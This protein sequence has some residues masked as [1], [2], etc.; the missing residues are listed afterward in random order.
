MCSSKFST[1][2]IT[3]HPSLR[4]FDF[5][6]SHNTPL[7]LGN[8]PSNMSTN[9]EPTTTDSSGG[10]SNTGG[11]SNPQP[12]PQAMIHGYFKERCVYYNTPWDYHDPNI[13]KDKAK[14][15]GWVYFVNNPCAYCMVST[16]YILLLR[17]W[18]LLLTPHEKKT[19]ILNEFVADNT[20]R[21]RSSYSTICRGLDEK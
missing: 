11:G 12:S 4:W 5:F 7:Q 17:W 3:H 14:N 13:D 19:R 9:P 10:T 1:L 16:S 15:H 18:S 2:E 8:K 20:G 21:E 6:V